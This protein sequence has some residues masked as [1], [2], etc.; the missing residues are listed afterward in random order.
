[1]KSNIKNTTLSLETPAFGVTE[2]QHSQPATALAFTYDFDGSAWPIIGGKL[3]LKTREVIKLLGSERILQRLRHHKWLKPL[4]PSKDCIYPASRVLQ[5]QK[6]M[7]NGE[8][9]PL[10]PSEI[11][12]RKAGVS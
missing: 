9:P 12:Q 6:R 4:Y 7:E 10:L 5:V 11:R 2:S 3:N 8:M 1:M